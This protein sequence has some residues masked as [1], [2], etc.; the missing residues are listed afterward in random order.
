LNQLAQLAITGV[1]VEKVG[2]PKIFSAANVSLQFS[3]LGL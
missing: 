2:Q 3:C 1:G